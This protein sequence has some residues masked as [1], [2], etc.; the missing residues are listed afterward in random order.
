MKKG[1]PRKLSGGR[2]FSGGVAVVVRRKPGADPGLYRRA[3]PGDATRT[4]LYPLR[5]LPS[6]LEPRYVLMR[7]GDSIN[8]LQ[9]LLVDEPKVRHR[10]ISVLGSIA[11]L[12][13]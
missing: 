9:A 2:S 8:R 4:E 10:N 5:E 6:L 12:P 3:V 1:S 11:M 13:G 7:V